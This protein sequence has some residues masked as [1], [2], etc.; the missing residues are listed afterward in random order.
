[1]QK[2]SAMLDSPIHFQTI[3]EL[4]ENIRRKCFSPVEVTK[5]FLNQIDRLDMTLKA[6]RCVCPD[7]ALAQA[8]SAE[9]NI[10]KG[11]DLGLLHGIPYS[12]KD[13]FDVK[14][15]PT[16]AGT[17]LLRENIATEDA[18]V[19]KKMATGGMVLLGKTNTVQFAYSGVGI[20]NDHGT[21]H[22]QW[23]ERPHVP[24]GSSSGSAVSVAGGLSA[25]SIGSDTGGSV[26]IPAALCGITGL[27]PTAGRVSRAGVY[28][29]SMTMDSFG[30]LARSAEDAAHIYQQ[31]QGIDLEDRTTFGLPLA[32]TVKPLRRGIKG[33]RLFFAETVF[34]DDIDPEVETAVRDCGKVFQGLGAHVESMDF[35]IAADAQ[36]LNSKRTI[37]PAE[38]YTVNQKWLENHFD[39]MD[40]LVAC[41]MIYG[42]K[43]SAAD[44]LKSI[45]E[46]RRLQVVAKKSLDSIDA[47]LVP[48]TCIP[49]LPLSELI[50]DNEAYKEKNKL[51]LRNTSIGNTLNLCSLSLP[52]GFTK[53]GLPIGLMIYGKPFTEAILLKIG[54]SFQVA[55]NWH[56][57][58]PDLSWIRRSFKK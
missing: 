16:T 53:E 45:C 4:A 33:L 58:V 14:G 51:Y 11:N 3:V 5:H 30:P 44:Y 46:L 17:N 29:L 10:Y 19:V 18:T 47:L 54:Y 55:T 50:S 43:V 48:T 22:N 13:L 41:R 31:I 38:A 8:K 27:K 12:I 20:N 26:R 40:P 2:N 49:T 9:I 52:C 32:E 56:Q 6:Y 57:R 7:F 36:D 25:V 23:S 28:P 39:Q 21:P 24:G 34:W 15:L 42:K 1:V 37:I 35:E